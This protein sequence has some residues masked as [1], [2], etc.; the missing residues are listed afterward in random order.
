MMPTLSNRNSISI[1]T[2][3]LPDA[4]L[5][6]HACTVARLGVTGISPT[7]EQVSDFST[8]ASAIIFRDAGLTVATLTHRSFG[9]ATA[10][11]AEVARDRL[12]RSID[13]AHCI[14]ACS[15][16]FTT[17]GRGDLTW[18]EAASRFAEA[19]APCAELARAAGIK[20]SLEPTSHLYAEISIAHRLADT[21][22][23]V[24]AADIHLGIDLFAC[25][26]DSDIAEAI[27]DGAGEAALVQVSDY[28]PGDRALPCRVVPGD[29]MAQLGRLIPQI[30]AAGFRGF[31]D[32]EIFGARVAAEGEE[33][34]LARAVAKLEQF[35][36]L[37]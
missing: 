25:W 21:I 20:L 11:E 19:I 5:A 29:G 9:F 7:L 31:Y 36:P 6:D 32:I 26:F 10:E 37:E 8:A 2:L 33:A 16:T 17:G 1:N 3:C 13:I 4:D 23:L 27:A 24:R 18:P 12:Q 30:H 35:I 14:S 22:E 34:A 15:I 28:A